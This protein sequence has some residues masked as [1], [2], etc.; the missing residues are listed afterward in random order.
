MG[1]CECGD[2]KLCGEQ[3]SESNDMAT[4]VSVFDEKKHP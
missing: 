3:E 2:T 4:K 1:N